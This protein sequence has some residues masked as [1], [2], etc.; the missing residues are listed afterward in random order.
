[1]DRRTPVGARAGS[2]PDDPALATYWARRRRHASPPLDRVSV[3]LLQEQH[4]RCPTCGGLLLAADQ[5]PSTPEW[6]QWSL[7]IRKAVRKNAATIDAVP[8]QPGDPVVVRLLHAWCWTPAP[9]P[10]ASASP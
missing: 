10:G 6:E 7:T 3:R 9:R 8:G 4:W 2:S 1:Q 5:E